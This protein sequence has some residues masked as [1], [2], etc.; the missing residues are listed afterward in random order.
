MQPQTAFK[1]VSANVT[2]VKL[3]VYLLSLMMS[4]LVGSR[5][6]LTYTHQFFI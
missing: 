2:I 6:M 4:L 5:T 3:Q 1:V